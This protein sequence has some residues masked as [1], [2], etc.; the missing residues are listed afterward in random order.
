MNFGKTIAALMI[1]AA[2]QNPCAVNAADEDRELSLIAAEQ[3]NTGEEQLDEL[4]PALTET[5]S[6]ERRE[7]TDKEKKDRRKKLRETRRE[8]ERENERKLRDSTR[9][10]DTQMEAESPIVIDPSVPEQTQEPV[11]EPIKETKPQPVAKTAPEP[12][13]E[14]EKKTVIEPSKFTEPITEENKIPKP[15][16][17]PPSTETVTGPNPKEVYANFAE[18]SR[19]LGFIPLY[20]P[21][22]SGYEITAIYAEPGIVEMQYGRRWEPEVGVAVRTYKRAEGEE[23]RDISGVDGVKWRVDTTTGTTIYLAKISE[24]EQVAAW[25]VGHYTFSAH[26]KNLSFAGFHALVADELVELSTHYYL[27]L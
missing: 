25:A 14:P 24:N 3:E 27:D 26:S 16:I 22:K 10:K 21:R 23:L 20:M 5:I 7:D 12:V 13:K 17:K 11:A 8:K 9:K 4:N 1:A 19:A 18:V 6:T 2:L 15:A